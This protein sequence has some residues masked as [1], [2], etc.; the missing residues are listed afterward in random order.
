MR[1]HV[2]L[3]L[4]LPFLFLSSQALGWGFKFGPIEVKSTKKTPI[5][6]AKDKVE[7]VVKKTGDVLEKAKDDVGDVLEEARDDIGDV[8]EEARDDTVEELVRTGKHINE[9][10]VAAGHFVENQAKSY[11]TTVS[12]V[13]KKVSEG[14]LLDAV[15]Q[16]AT[17]P[18]KNTEQH[19]AQAVSE[20]SL[21]NNTATAAA[22]IYGGPGGAAAYAAWYTYRQTNDLQLALKTGI[23]VGAT[24]QGLEM[25]NGLPSDTIGDLSKKTLASA[26]IG[27]AAV[28]ASGGDEKEVIEA[29]VK[30]AA[31]TLAREHY[32]KLTDQEIEGRA[33]TKG[34]V[35]K[36]DPNVRHQFKVLL[37]KNGEPILD[38]KGNLQIDIRSMPR[39]ISHV[40]LASADP[41]ASFFSGAET[42]S[43]M[44]G[45]AKIPYMNDMAYYHDQWAA[46][47]QMQGI[48]VQAT[49]LPAM[50]LVV[51]GSDTPLI[52]QVTQENIDNKDRLK[53]KSVDQKQA[54][55]ELKKQ[56]NVKLSDSVV[57]VLNEKAGADKK[58]AGKTQQKLP[59][60]SKKTTS[61]PKK[62]SSSSGLPK[63]VSHCQFANKAPHKS[64]FQ[65]QSSHIGP[66]TLCQHK[67][68]EREFWI[69]VRDPFQQPNLCLI[70]TT[71][72]GVNSTAIGGPVCLKVADSSKVYRLRV[73]KD[74]KGFSKFKITGAMIMKDKSYYY[75]A[76]YSQYVLSPDAYLFCLQVLENEL[77]PSYCQTFKTV[78]QYVYHQF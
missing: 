1:K 17:D 33:P 24:S 58:L 53:T 52:K 75:P 32:K 67:T 57:L 34:A 18:V 12:G 74:R 20:S 61:K 78:G 72:Q 36:A 47:A 37:D 62:K 9:A 23:I 49:I 15:W 64:G 38:A 45:I 39:N 66:Y 71:H 19:F 28:A 21:L 73:S 68:K 59:V 55:A 43:L 48:E 31:I 76:P 60:V 5:H 30:G 65:N 42:S 51:A 44:Q 56:G 14:K 10:A 50:V 22:S 54:I 8:L 35:P 6:S 13:Q 27:G 26:S 69:Q 3:L 70:P 11:V 25:V 41:N 77:N 46:L 40:G 7:K 4:F 2:P 16:A 29:F 63:E